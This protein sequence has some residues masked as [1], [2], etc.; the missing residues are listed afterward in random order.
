MFNGESLLLSLYVWLFVDPMDCSMPGF[1]V[2]P[3]ICSISCPSSWWCY[4]TILFSTAL[5]S[6]CLQSLPAS[7]SFPISGLFPSGGQSIEASALALVLLMNTQGWFP[8]GL[9]GLITLRSKRLSRVFFS[10]IWKHQFFDTQPSLL[11][12][13]HICT[14]LL[15]KS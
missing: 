6:L 7:E 15:E 4:I 2:L 13:F 11:S 14:W 9:T 1:P 10:T 12:S 3:R 5:F 8:L